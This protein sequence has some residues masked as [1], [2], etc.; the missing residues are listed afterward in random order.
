MNTAKLEKW[1]G[2][3]WVGDDADVVGYLQ[4]ALEYNDPKLF[5]KC[6]NDVARARGIIPRDQKD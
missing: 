6:L 4:T 1:D 3:D 5:S 2:A